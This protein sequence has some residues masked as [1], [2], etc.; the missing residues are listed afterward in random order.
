MSHLRG[1]RK[2]IEPKC[3]EFVFDGGLESSVRAGLLIELIKYILYERQQIPAPYDW[4]VSELKQFTENMEK[5]ADPRSDKNPSVNRMQ[6]RRDTLRMKRAIKAI[7]NLQQMFKEISDHTDQSVM[8]SHDIDMSGIEP[9]ESSVIDLSVINKAEQ[10][11]DLTNTS[12][13]SMTSE[14][15]D[16]TRS[17]LR[18]FSDSELSSK[19]SSS[20]NSSTVTSGYKYDS[21]S[22]ERDCS[23]DEM[24][25]E[26]GED[27]MYMW[28]QAPIRFKGYKCKQR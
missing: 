5:D 20:L 21:M 26:N 28:F 14:D 27:N 24:L 19:T 3:H 2:E 18:Q 17:L 7:S 22:S 8:G 13:S 11:L 12:S 25:Q 16:S 10:L 4:I 23:H 1:K 15:V 6:L 9:L